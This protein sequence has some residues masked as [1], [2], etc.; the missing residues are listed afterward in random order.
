MADDDGPS[1]KGLTGK[2]LFIYLVLSLITASI[3]GAAVWVYDKYDKYE[4]DRQIAELNN[5]IR[6]CSSARSSAETLLKYREDEAKELSQEI[7]R[8]SAQ[9]TGDVNAFF[10]TYQKLLNDIINYRGIWNEPSSSHEQR[11]KKIAE[12]TSRANAFV[13]F[14][15]K[16]RAVMPYLCGFLDGDLPDNIDRGNADQVFN[17]VERLKDGLDGQWDVLKTV[18]RDAA[19]KPLSQS[20]CLCKPQ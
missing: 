17:T 20:P 14:V 2:H 3:G 13:N 6:E 5:Q 18:V 10:R 4:T 15:K 12:L 8:T 11:Q 19:Q 9:Q 7:A 1:P 16:W